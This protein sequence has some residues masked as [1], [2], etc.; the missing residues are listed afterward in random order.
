MFSCRTFTLIAATLACLS[1]AL[2]T[3]LTACSPP[4]GTGGGGGGGGDGAPAPRSFSGV[5]YD[6]IS[7]APISGAEVAF[8][9]DS[10]TTGSG[11]AFEFALSGPYTVRSE[12]FSVAA[13]DHAFLYVETLDVDT[14]VDTALSLPLERRD[15]STYASRTT[16]SGEVYYD[17]DVEIQAG[18]VSVSIHGANGTFEEFGVINYEDSGDYGY[19]VQTAVRS[20]DSLVVAEVREVVSGGLGRPD[21]VF[22]RAGVDLASPGP[23]P[24]TVDVARPSPG[25]YVP[26]RILGGSAGDVARGYYRSSYGQVP[27]RFL[28]TR[29]GGE[30]DRAEDVLATVELDGSGSQEL[31]LYNPAGWGSVVLVAGRDDVGAPDGHGRRWLSAS[32]PQTAGG[33]L[34]LVDVDVTLGPFSYPDLDSLHYDDGTLALDEVTGADLYVHHLESEPADG[35]VGTVV[36]RSEGVQ[37]PGALLTQLGGLVMVDLL[38]IQ[39]FGSPSLPPSFL[40]SRDIPPSLRL[41]EV[42]G[43]DTPYERSVNV[44]PGGTV[45]IGLE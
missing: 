23:G 35:P 24:V 15:P 43:A 29:A 27:C 28:P 21:F 39:D 12:A 22:Y 41:G 36:A 37:L 45:E 1:F 3:L 13:P 16:I 11:G 38:L 10:E 44:P 32:P 30:P 4:A 7:G 18:S 40:E 31:A 26:V 33:D 19:S 5:L 42:Y 25:D 17:R 6:A 14:S 9:W 20:A 8:G 34:T 2:L